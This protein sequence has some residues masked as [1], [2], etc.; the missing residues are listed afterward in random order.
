MSVERRMIEFFERMSV[1]RGQ[2]LVLAREA[3]LPTNEREKIILL[4][5]A[6]ELLVLLA[7]KRT[8]KTIYNY[9]FQIFF[10]KYL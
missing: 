7:G 6:H 1:G 8:K 2:P 10:K 4:S 5:P 3:C 9:F